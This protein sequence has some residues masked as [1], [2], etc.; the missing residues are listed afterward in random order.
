MRQLLAVAS[1]TFPTRTKKGTPN[2]QR[3]L[4]FLYSACR[5]CPEQMPKQRSPRKLTNT[6]APLL[7]GLYSLQSVS[8]V[9]GLPDVTTY[10]ATVEEILQWKDTA[11]RTGKFDRFLM[12]HAADAW[13]VYAADGK[14][15]SLCDSVV[16]RKVGERPCHVDVDRDILDIEAHAALGSRFHCVTACEGHAGSPAADHSNFGV[17]VRTM[18]RDGSP[19]DLHHL[20]VVESHTWEC[21]VSGVYADVAALSRKAQDTFLDY[22]PSLSRSLPIDSADHRK[23]LI[24]RMAALRTNYLS[25]VCVDVGAH[26]GLDEEELL[27]MRLSVGARGDEFRRKLAA[28]LLRISGTCPTPASKGAVE[29]FDT[30]KLCGAGP[31]VVAAFRL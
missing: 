11:A 14:L 18:L 7:P 10:R 6:P 31:A 29:K 5:V 2:V 25:D 21:R 28:E 24:N 8:S 27:S 9:E 22:Y 16:D 3:N 17:I 15:E 30:A 1:P 12:R 26:S 19:E 20:F 23:L 4:S 13:D